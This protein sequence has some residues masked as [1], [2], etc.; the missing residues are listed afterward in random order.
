MDSWLIEWSFFEITQWENG[1]QSIQLFTLLHNQ[2]TILGNTN[3]SKLLFQTI[4]HTVPTITHSCCLHIQKMCRYSYS[5]FE[6]RN[7][8]SLYSYFKPQINTLIHAALCNYVLSS[9]QLY[10]PNKQKR[11]KASS[12]AEGG[13]SLCFLMCYLKLAEMNTALNRIIK[14]MDYGFIRVLKFCL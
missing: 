8:S 10:L 3:E 11:H 14:N 7:I 5:M 6:C 4:D 12:T 13:I 9:F 2:N 1:I